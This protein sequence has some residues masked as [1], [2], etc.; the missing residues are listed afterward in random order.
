MPMADRSLPANLCGNLG[1]CAVP[2]EAVGVLPRRCA[3][4]DLRRSDGA[5]DDRVSIAGAIFRACVLRIDFATG[6]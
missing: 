4:A 2:A 3:A 1:H 5:A 6:C